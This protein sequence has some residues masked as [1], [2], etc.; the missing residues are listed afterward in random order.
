MKKQVNNPAM[1]MKCKFSNAVHKILEPNVG[2]KRSERWRK[3]NR[4]KYNFTDAQKLE[5][6]NQIL[7]LH[8]EISKEIV[9]YQFDKREKKRVQKARVERGYV[10]KKKT[11]L[12]DYLASKAS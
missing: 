12:A 2:I 10:A 6:F 8:N 3:E 4:E 5:M 7:A 1:N 11:K 9:S